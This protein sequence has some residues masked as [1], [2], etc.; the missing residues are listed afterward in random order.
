MSTVKS[1]FEFYLSNEWIQQPGP[2]CKNPRGRDAAERRNE[3]KLPFSHDGLQRMYDACETRYGKQEVKW[4]RVIHHHRAEGEYVRYNYKW[5][6]EDLTDFIS[7][8]V[9]MGLRISDVT[10]FHTDRMQQTGEIHV[11]TTK[12]GTHVHTWVPEW[13]QER[14]RARAWAIR[15]GPPN[16]THCFPWPG[17]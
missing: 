7:V 14:I 2:A 16:H 9:Y 8:S 10:T 4:S 13:L 5:T 17:T 15:S 6:G 1:F 11:R 12:A 3:Q